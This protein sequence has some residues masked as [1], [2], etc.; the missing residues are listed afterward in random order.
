[1]RLSATVAAGSSP[2]EPGFAPAEDVTLTWR[3]FTEAADQAGLSRRFGGIHFRDGD[4]AAREMGRHVGLQAW[5][6]AA[7]HFGGHAK[8][9]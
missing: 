8:R 4:L 2:V 5:K 3:T 9:D 6:K 1:M 7:A